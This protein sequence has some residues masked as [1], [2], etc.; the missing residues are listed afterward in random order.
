M[1]T[2]MQE[3]LVYLRSHRYFVSLELMLHIELSGIQQRP[4]PQQPQ[5]NLLSL[6]K[7]PEISHGMY[8]RN[9]KREYEASDGKI[10]TVRDI[11]EVLRSSVRWS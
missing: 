6:Q 3:R 11:R 8:C 4:L 1:E 7:C 2:R 10:V 9:R 5:I